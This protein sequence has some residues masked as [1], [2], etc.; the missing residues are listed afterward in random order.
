MSPVQ[1]EVCPVCQTVHDK[2]LCPS[3]SSDPRSEWKKWY[4]ALKSANPDAYRKAI[5]SAGGLSINH[6]IDNKVS[7]DIER[8]FV[9][10][11]CGLLEIQL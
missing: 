5:E 3:V 6:R 7:A 9:V 10:F 4:R 11:A 2:P 1:T 8:S